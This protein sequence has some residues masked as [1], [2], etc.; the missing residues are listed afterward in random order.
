MDVLS[1]VCRMGMM[2]AQ[3]MNH[4]ELLRADYAS[5]TG[6][7]FEHFYCPILY[8]DDDTELCRAHVINKAFSDSDR[9]WTVQRADVDSWYGTRFEDDFL[10]MQMRNKPIARQ[11]LT[12]PDLGRRFRPTLTINGEVVEYYPATGPVPEHHTGVEF[13]VDGRPVRLGLK[14]SPSE[15]IDVPDIEW[16]F[17]VDKDFRLPALV[18]ILKAAHLTMFHLLGYRYALSAGGHFLGKTVL[19]DFFL[20][21]QGMERALALQEAEQHFKEFSGMC[22]PLAAPSLDIPGTLTNRVCQLFMSGMEPWAILIVVRTGIH[23]HAAV[24]PIMDDADS[25]A[26]FVEFLRNPSRMIETRPA[27]LIE[28]HIEFST[29]SRWFEWPDAPWDRPDPTD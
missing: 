17:L 6:R 20:K 21:C 12:D 19:G 1:D 3:L 13:D 22:R 27:I 24:V 11:A 5:V 16:E 4:L 10:A 9:Q 18:S 26:R 8:R 7:P 29:A 28:D 25:A 23:K 14:L 15:L 2:N